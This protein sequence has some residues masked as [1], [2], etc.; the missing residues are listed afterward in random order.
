MALNMR[1]AIQRILDY[2]DDDELLFRIRVELM[3]LWEFAVLI[4][5]AKGGYK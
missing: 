2:L 1:T 4:A 3:D 5:T